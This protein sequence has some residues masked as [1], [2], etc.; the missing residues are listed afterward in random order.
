M[1][2]LYILRHGKSSWDHPEI[3]DFDRPLLSKGRKRTEIIAAYIKDNKLPVDLIISSPGVRAYQTAKIIAEKIQCKLITHEDL[4]P[5]YSSQVFDV[6]FS[7]PDKLKS[8]MIVGHN[9]GL[10]SL[11]NDLIDNNY[12]WLPT[13]GLAMAS[14]NTN[15]W[16]QIPVVAKTFS[17]I[18]T[19]K[20]LELE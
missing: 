13:S 8:I 7:Q 1:K 6:I 2:T 15:T 9:P 16:L 3:D 10:T 5:G 18:V 4:Y 19:P 20:V 12:E 14:F 11:V 17:K